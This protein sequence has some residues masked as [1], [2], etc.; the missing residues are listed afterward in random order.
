MS[1]TKQLGR[2][3]DTVTSKIVYLYTK[4]LITSVLSLARTLSLIGKSSALASLDI[5][6]CA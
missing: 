4:C 2:S 5:D 1:I 3:R 6:G